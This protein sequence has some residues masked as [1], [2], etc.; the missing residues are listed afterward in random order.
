MCLQVFLFE[1]ISNT[2]DN[3]FTTCVFCTVSDPVKGLEE[4]KR[5]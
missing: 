2:F 3:I 5:V 1:V 4:I